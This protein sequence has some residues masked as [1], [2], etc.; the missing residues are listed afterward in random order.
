MSAYPKSQPQTDRRVSFL[1]GMACGMLAVPTA[2]AVG[3]VLSRGLPAA[4]LFVFLLVI[5]TMSL[6]TYRGD[7][8]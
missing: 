3:Y 4:A 7:P 5:L 1:K 8:Q 2:A 6:D